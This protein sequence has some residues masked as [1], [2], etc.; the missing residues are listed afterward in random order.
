[1]KEITFF[2]ELLWLHHMIF[3]KHGFCT[4]QPKN[5]FPFP[6][7]FCFHLSIFSTVPSEFMHEGALSVCPLYSYSDNWML[8]SICILSPSPTHT[9]TILLGISVSGVQCSQR[10]PLLN[11]YPLRWN[12]I[13]IYGLPHLFE[14]GSKMLIASKTSLCGSA[15]SGFIV[16]GGL[17]CVFNCLCIFVYVLMCLFVCV[18]VA[19]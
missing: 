3:F 11:N 10:I 1:M 12:C 15:E 18:S 17:D 2:R 8:F 5:R 9:Y 13:T 19:L 16:S 4:R 14:S 6:L 7:F